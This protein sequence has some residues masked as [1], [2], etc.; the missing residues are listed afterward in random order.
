[1]RLKTC[2]AIFL[3]VSTLV[4]G[5]TVAQ[6]AA[7]T[8]DSRAWHGVWRGTIGNAAVQVCLQHTDY[9]DFGAYYYMRHLQI[10]SLG[11]VDGKPGTPAGSVWTEGRYS[12]KADKGPFWRITSVANGR[13]DGVW[14]D[15]SKSLPI[16]LTMVAAE[17]SAKGDDGDAGPCGSMAFSLPRFTKPVVTTKAAKVGGTAYTRVLVDIGK[18][19]KD[20]G[21]ETFQLS[22][23]SPAVRR[24]NAELYKDVPTG[25]EHADYFQC[26]MSALGQNGLDG[27]QSSALSPETLTPGFLVVADFESWDCGGAHP[28]GGTIYQT[29]DLRTGAKIN[30]YDGFTKA[31]LTQ[32]VHDAGTANAYSEVTFTAPFKAMIIR[33]LATPEPDCKAAIETADTWS[34]RLTARGMAFTPDLPHAAAACGDD[35]VIPYARLAPYLTPNGKALVAAFEAEVKGRK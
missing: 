24:V 33:A 11:K 31:A 5:A 21:F 10:I 18:Q 25:P 35:A 27:D 29:W 4:C 19:F 32:T 2:S 16:A 13:M 26:T 23:T 14:T 20:S 3:A 17:K 8:T 22:G 1:M 6:A 28:D 15:G 30:P 7:P 9:E 12:D 34:A